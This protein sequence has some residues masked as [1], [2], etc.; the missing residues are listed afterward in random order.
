MNPLV[1]NAAFQQCVTDLIDH[2][3]RSAHECLVDRGG[4]DEAVGERTHFGAIEPSVEQRHILLL[5]AEYV[6]ESEPAE[7]AVLQIFQL[8]LEEDARLTAVGAPRRGA[9]AAARGAPPRLWA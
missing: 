7:I 8:F 5:A 6:I 9:A 1:A 2:G 4:R 3:A